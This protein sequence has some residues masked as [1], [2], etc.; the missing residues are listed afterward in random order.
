MKE[1]FEKLLEAVRNNRKY[2][3]W[4]SKVTSDEYAKNVVEEAEEVVN[5]VKNKNHDNVEEEIGDLLWDTI[6]LAVI[7]EEEGKIN[8]ADIIPRILEKMK[9][10][11][12]HIF[13]QKT[14]SREEARKIWF[15]A[16]ERQKAK[17]GDVNA[18]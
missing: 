13:E 8:S 4:A 6:M 12:P 7:S 16:K 17:G 15:E 1:S 3:P 5:A 2:D 11:K 9:E 18:R 14:I 10:R